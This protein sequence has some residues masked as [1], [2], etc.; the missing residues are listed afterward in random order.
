MY[1]V[2]LA[3]FTQ[4]WVPKGHKN[5]NGTPNHLKFRKGRLSL[6]MSSKARGIYDWVISR[7]G[8]R[9]LQAAGD[10]EVVV[11]D[12]V[13]VSKDGSGNFTTIN[14]AITA[15]PNNSVASDGY[16]L[17]YVTAGVSEK[18]SGWERE[19]AEGRGGERRRV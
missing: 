6:K 13:V 10:E 14:D 9:L 18:D 11:K 3:L 7:P 4:G 1:S 19:G 5:P 17:V 15:A 2:S 12:I 16:F 8:R